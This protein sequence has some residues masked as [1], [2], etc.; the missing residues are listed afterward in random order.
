MRWD[1]RSE[2]FIK[3]PAQWIL[4]C[5]EH[6]RQRERERTEALKRLQENRKRTLSGSEIKTAS[7]P[8]W[9]ILA[10]V[11][12]EAYIQPHCQSSRKSDAMFGTY[13]HLKTEN[14][15]KK[16]FTQDFASS[17]SFLGSH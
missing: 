14:T 15:E 17:I 1:F 3:C 8:S 13:T 16:I 11:G 10:A 2:R 9:V 5:S 6:S 12:L 7:T 4:N